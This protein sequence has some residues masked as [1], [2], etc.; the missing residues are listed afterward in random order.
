MTCE[1]LSGEGHSFHVL[2][3]F[4]FD[5][6]PLT[7]GLRVVTYT[8]WQHLASLG[9][10]INP[11]GKAHNLILVAVL[12]IQSV[13][14][15]LPSSYLLLPSQ[16]AIHSCRIGQ[17]RELPW[18]PLELWMVV[19]CPLNM[20]GSE[21]EKSGETGNNRSSHWAAEPWS[22]QAS[23]DHPLNISRV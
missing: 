20:G 2:S 17:Q 10:S 4:Q 16:L 21:G 18:G 15:T 22:L 14:S 23:G 3:V 5:R 11:V 1:L 7:D 9:A 6:P 13:G 19:E 12:D 8:I